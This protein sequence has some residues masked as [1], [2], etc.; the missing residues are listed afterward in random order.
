MITHS[1]YECEICHKIYGDPDTASRCEGRGIPK[2]WPRGLIFAMHRADVHRNVTYSVFAEKSVTDA[3]LHDPQLFVISSYDKGGITKPYRL[4]NLTHCSL[5]R[6]HSEV[7]PAYDS[8]KQM[9][10]YLTNTGIPVTVWDG[11]QPVTLDEW[12]KTRKCICSGRFFPL[13]TCTCGALGKR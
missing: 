4:A 8:F 2:A 13:P 9:V 11:T 7:D 12:R 6:E 10:R 3:E 1:T 5:S